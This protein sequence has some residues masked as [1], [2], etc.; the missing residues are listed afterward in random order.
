MARRCST[1]LSVV[2][3]LAMAA[4][5]GSSAL[6]QEGDAAPAAP[7]ASGDLPHHHALSLI[8]EP[9]YGPDFKHFDWVNPDAP[10]GGAVRFATEGTFDSLNPF[11]IKGVP[12]GPVGMIYDSL[13]VGSPDEESTEY[14]LIAAWV[15]YPADY[16]W[17]KFGLRTEARFHDGTP[18]TPEDVVFSLDALKKA[19]PMYARYYKN[20]VK[21]E[22]TGDHEVTFTFDIAG[23]RELPQI[24]GQLTVFPKHFWEATGKNG[25]PRD[26]AKSTL[27]I[28]LGSGPYKI[29]TVD[30]GNR[31]VLERVK[32]YWAKDLPVRIGQYNFDEL[33]FQYFR[34]RTAA[35][36]D[37]KAG[38]ADFW[39][40]NTASA[41][42]TQFNFDAIKKGWVKKEVIPTKGVARM[43][44]FVFNTRRD[45]FK[46]PR[47]RQ[48]FNYAFNF[49]D[50]NRSV[51]FGQYTRVASYFDNSELA[52]KGLPTGR[53]LEI[54]KEFEKDLPPEVFTTEWKNPVYATPEDTRKNLGMAMKLLNEAGWQIKP[55]SSVLV[56]AAG[57]P[58]KVEFL[59][60]SDAFQRHVAFY[61]S[62]LRKI[63]V[64]ATVRVVD[65]A[66][67]EQRETN[68]DFDI[69]IDSFPQSN[70]P[71]NEQ[72]DFWGSGAADQPGSR[73][74]IGI[75]SPVIDALIE[76]LV[77]A[78][79]REGVVAYT[80]ALDRVLLWGHY[81]VPQWYN[82]YEW[83]ATW[84]VFGHPA[85]LPSL[86]SAFTQ[87]WWI[88][89][90]KEQAL[91]A[92]RK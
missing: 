25:E 24:L 85:T 21:A 12:A 30:T 5:S 58:L 57:Q 32:D 63:G 75:K 71:G 64:D 27:E 11:S 73:N 39:R 78:P 70:S 51:L 60:G 28:P 3:A 38:R 31:I 46:D 14:G 83:I 80:R 19:H 53:E 61:V 29:K 69:I 76:K 33:R 34:E 26:L 16:S 20:V 67:Y 17:A 40:E 37:F 13:M 91:A 23:N 35:F 56:N 81:V 66:Q 42:S 62:N 47:V 4:A 48:A 10:K 72:R 84:D 7:A 77:L 54:L 44:G 50:L 68:F 90:A 87:V 65:D 89:P 36:E 6:A 9:K 86:T 8:G 92:H 18:I 52:A 88:D 2:A 79:D 59:L 49:E 82:P 43:Q 55:G 45:K 22:K 74:T 41:W 15:S 1:F